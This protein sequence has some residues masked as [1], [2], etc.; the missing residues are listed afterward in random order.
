MPN[1]WQRSVIWLKKLAGAHRTQRFRPAPFD[2]S[3]AGVGHLDAGRASND[4]DRLV[5]EVEN[6]SDGLPGGG[7]QLRTRPNREAYG[8][9]CRLGGLGMGQPAA[10]RDGGETRD[11][12]KERR[13]N[14]H[15]APPA[16]SVDAMTALDG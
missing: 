16:E 9:R 10:E 3:D 7:S 8:F 4:L 15:L 2:V 13:Q 12:L 6:R 1:W 14:G 5:Q 11:C